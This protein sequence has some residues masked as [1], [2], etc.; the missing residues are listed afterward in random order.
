MSQTFKNFLGPSFAIAL[1]EQLLST[2]QFKWEWVEHTG[3]NHVDNGNW[4]FSWTHYVF[5][6]DQIFSDLYPFLMPVVLNIGDAI[7][8]DVKQ[9]VRIRIGCITKTP[10]TVVHSPH[11]DSSFPHYTALLYLND[12]DGETIIYNETFPFSENSITHDEYAKN[13]NFTE[14]EKHFPEFN[15]VVVFN[16]AHYHSSSS[17]TI[18]NRR[19]VVTMNFIGEPKQ[20]KVTR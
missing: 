15:K 5:Q 13:L 7:G 10:E 20:C 12:S 4:D 8:V 19:I 17:P 3:Y 16:G 14:M 18:A 11:I 9:V 1:K 2:N 6:D